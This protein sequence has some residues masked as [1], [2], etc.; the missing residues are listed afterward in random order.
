MP[1]TYWKRCVYCGG[2]GYHIKR[3]A[4]T[5]NVYREDCKPCNG[6]GGKNT[7]VGQ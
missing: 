1:D 4:T 6:Q 2:T 3:N 7:P 5:G